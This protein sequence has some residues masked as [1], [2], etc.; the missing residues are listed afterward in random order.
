MRYIDYYERALYNHILSSQQASPITLIPFFRLHDSRYTLY[1]GQSAPDEWQQKQQVLAQ[2]AQMEAK[3]MA[4]T[5]DSVQPGEQQ[6]ESDHFFMASK[7]EAGLN[8]NRHW[9]HAQDWFSYQLDAK[10][11]LQPVLRLTYF[12]LDAGRR[13]DILI[14]DKRLAEVTMSADKGPTFYNVDYPQFPPTSF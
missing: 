5:L 6:P 12:G 8:G 2:K 9:R 14:N 13:F 4:Q 10:G 3:L 11:E 7:S 1:F